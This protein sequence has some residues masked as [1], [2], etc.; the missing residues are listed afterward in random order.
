MSSAWP[1]LPLKPWQA[2]KDTL[3][4]FTQVVGKIRLAKAPEE[5]EWGHTALYLTGRG[6]T[7]T[8]MPA[9]ERSFQIDF[10]LLGHRLYIAVNDGQVR[11]IDLREHSVA[12]FYREVMEALRWLKIDVQI[13]PAPQEVANTIPLDQ[14]TEHATYDGEAVERFFRALSSIDLV[15]KEHRAPYRGRHTPVNFFWG[16][17]DLSYERFSG[18]PASPPPG[19]SRLMRLSMDAELINAGFW[20]G[21]ARFPEPAFFSYAYPKPD[22]IENASLEPKSAFWHKDIGEFMLRYEDVRT[23]ASPRQDILDFLHSTCEAGT[24]RG[25]WMR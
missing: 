23:S 17:F 15:L 22:G 13:S 7:T 9:D 6:L 10:D 25:G 24:R 16:S 11:M 2:T 8:P 14:D 3:H 1:E 18:K 19:V 5:A 21:D 4:M 20:P 12:A